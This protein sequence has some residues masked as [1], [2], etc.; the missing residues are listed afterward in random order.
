MALLELLLEADVLLAQQPDRAHVVQPHDQLRH[1][2]RLGDEVRGPFPHR[3][4]RPVDRAV[5]GDDHHRGL[6]LQGLDALAAGPCRPSGHDEIG[7]HQVV[8]VLLEERRPLDAVLGDVDRPALLAQGVGH[9]DP[10]QRLVLDDQQSVAADRHAA[11]PPARSRRA[12]R[13]S[14]PGTWCPCRRSDSTSMVPP[15]AATMLSLTASPSPV[16]SPTSRVV[17]NG[18]KIRS[19]I[20][21]GIPVPG[22]V[23]LGDHLAAAH[24]GSQ[25]EGA[26]VRHRL[27]GVEH[28]VEEQL[29]HLEVVGHDQRLVGVEVEARPRRWPAAADSRPAPPRGGGCG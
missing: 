27:D 16:P 9:G 8:Q 6:G 14:E 7:E 29:L 22:V 10:Q 20:S 1:R 23:H 3:L 13:R 15:W 18:S 21:S 12:S 26:A 24:P 19:R 17:K 25:G 28:Q 4:H 11:P 2:E 5:G